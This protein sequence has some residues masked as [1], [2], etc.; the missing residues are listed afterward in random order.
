MGGELL[1]ILKKA[2]AGLK[3]LH[4]FG[5]V[6]RDIACRNILLGQ[7]SNG[8]VSDATEVRISDF[9]LT[10]QMEEPQNRNATQKTVS[11]FGPLKWM[12]PESIKAKTYSKRSDVFMFAITMWE[13]FYG[14]EPY[15]KQCN[16]VQLALEITTKFR[17]PRESDVDR[18]KYEFHAMPDGY[19]ELMC[20]CWSHE[21]R[22]R[23]TFS[24][25]TDAL[26][27]ISKDPNPVTRIP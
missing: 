5:L 16:V 9:G 11:S 6:H 12:A 1:L 22:Q 21:P 19:E 14:M 27:C 17:R 3:F 26:A 2:A 10:R 4:S 8:R 15:P 25:I 18:R 20:A 23:P 7:L 13:L 24:K